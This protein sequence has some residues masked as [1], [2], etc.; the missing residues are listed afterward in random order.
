MNW[1][2][3]SVKDSRF[4]DSVLHFEET[5]D[6]VIAILVLKNFRKCFMKSP[7]YICYLSID[8]NGRTTYK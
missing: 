8:E 7:S 4:R 2:S 6:A 3:E 1:I 5:K